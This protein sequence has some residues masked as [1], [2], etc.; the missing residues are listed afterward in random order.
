M[1]NLNSVFA[2]FMALWAVFFVYQI[3]VGRRLARLQD[4]IERLKSRLK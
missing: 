3:T 2:A 4:E 1:E